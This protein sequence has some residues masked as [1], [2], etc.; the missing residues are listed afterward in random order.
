MQ[1][2]RRP[3][4][5]DCAAIRPALKAARE[6]MEQHDTRRRIQLKN[7]D[8]IC[9]RPIGKR[10]EISAT[11]T[12]DDDPD[13]EGIGKRRQ[14]RKEVG[15]R[16]VQRSRAYLDR[17]LRAERSRASLKFRRTP[18]D[19]HQVEPP[20][21]QAFCYRFADSGSASGDECPLSEASQV[22]HCLISFQVSTRL[23]L[24][25]LPCDA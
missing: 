3:K 10:V 6:V 21:R 16:N 22:S 23:V 8:M 4:Q 9:E 2:H 7:G 15:L 14:F 5:H 11:G 13:I 17:V 1:A 24:A 18:R 25:R 12:S 20:S 19:Q